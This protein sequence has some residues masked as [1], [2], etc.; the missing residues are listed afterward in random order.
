[1][2]TII[3]NINGSD[4]SQNK[5]ISAALS[6]IP[7]KVTVVKVPITILAKNTVQYNS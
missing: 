5:N 6:T 4:N 7:V 1:M 2:M 3:T